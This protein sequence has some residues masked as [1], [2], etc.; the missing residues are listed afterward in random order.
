[1][2]VGLRGLLS[3][4]TCALKAE[5]GKLDIKRREPGILFIDSLF[6]LATMMYYRFLCPLNVIGDVIQHHDPI[7]DTCHKIANVYQVSV[8]QCS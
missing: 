3:H 7:K 6:K 8:Q 4:L 5:P 2:L 1:M